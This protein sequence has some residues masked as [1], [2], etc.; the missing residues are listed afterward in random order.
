MMP[1]RGLAVSH[2]TILRWVIRYVLEFE[3]RGADGPET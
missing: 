1:E 2:T 3:K